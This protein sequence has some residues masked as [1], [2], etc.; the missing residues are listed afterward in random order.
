MPVDGEP[1]TI[2]NFSRH[3]E[4]LSMHYRFNILSAR[5]ACHLLQVAAGLHQNG[6][7]APAGPG[8]PAAPAGPGAA[9]APPG[10]GAAAAPADPDAAAAPEVGGVPN[11]PTPEGYTRKAHGGQLAATTGDFMAMVQI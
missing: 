3:N 2:L 8:A 9:A 6:A 4:A 1:H 5:R 7:A 11:L 10:T